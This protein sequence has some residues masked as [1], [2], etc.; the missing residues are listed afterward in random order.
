[1]HETDVTPIDL[2][3]FKHDIHS[4]N[5]EDGILQKLFEVLGVTNGCFCE[6]GAWD[7]KHLSNTY[8]LYTRGWRGC[9]IEGDA[10]RFLDLKKNITRSD[11]ACVHAFVGTEGE[12]SLDNILTRSLPDG[13]HVDLLSIDIDSDDLA[14]WQ[15]LRRYRPSVV[16]IEYNPTIPID[17]HYVNPRGE[18]KGNSPRSI[19]EFGRQSG[20]ELVAVTQTN[21]IFLDAPLNRG[22]FRTFE[23]DA[24]ELSLGYR[25]FFGMD[26]SL[27]RAFVNGGPAE[28]R[29]FYNVPWS[30]ALLPQPLPRR[31]RRFDP[32]GWRKFYPL[33]TS[34]LSA[35]V[36]R[37]TTAVPFLL[38]GIA[39][40]L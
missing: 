38:K 32:P 40:R 12:N 33:V 39:K 37:P 15:S 2:N 6:F 18:N 28:Q 29:E 20:Y 1:M 30:R 16:V 14:V 19:F 23:L 4:Q 27:L 11:T 31:L 26:G 22:R 17:I 13:V 10:T 7:G 35:V 36:R 3:G 9:Y 25:F 5:G 8:L 24:P 21:L 34:A